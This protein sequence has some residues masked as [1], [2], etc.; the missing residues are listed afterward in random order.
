ME[1]MTVT[2]IVIAGSRTKLKR[3]PITVNN[4]YN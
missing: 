2:I 3:L 4:G 1:L